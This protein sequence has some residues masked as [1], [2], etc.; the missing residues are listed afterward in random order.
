M[1]VLSPRSFQTRTWIFMSYFLLGLTLGGQGRFH[2]M[3][4][5]K[6][7]RSIFK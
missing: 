3:R 7:C 5:P 1:R 2:A 6:L 4:G